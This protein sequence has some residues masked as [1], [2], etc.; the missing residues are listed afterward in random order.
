MK[1]NSTPYI[2]LN[3]D[4]SARRVQDD[5]QCNT[6]RREPF[7][8]MPSP[9][10]VANYMKTVLT[11]PTKGYYTTKDVFGQKGDFTTSLEISQFFGEMVGLWILRECNK[12]H[13]KSFQILELGPGREVSPVLAKIQKENL[14][15]F[16]IQETEPVLRK[17]YYQF[18]KTIDNVEIYWHKSTSS[19]REISSVNGGVFRR[20][21][22]PGKMIVGSI[23]IVLLTFAYLSTEGRAVHKF[24]KRFPEGRAVHNFKKRFPGIGILLMLITGFF[25]TYIL[26]VLC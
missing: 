20:L 10:S 9:I 22:H 23:A 15:D 11:H 8:T 14:C 19:Q 2:P 21:I 17:K 12:I 13:Y 5:K 16:T 24:K 3:E 18:G 1:R 6:Y 7:H 4:K 26:L 25:L